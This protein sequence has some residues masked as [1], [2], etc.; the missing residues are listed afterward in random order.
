[1]KILIRLSLSLIVALSMLA[2]TP[3][4]CKVP[5]QSPLQACLEIRR[6]LIFL[7]VNDPTLQQFQY[8]AANWNSPTRQAHLLRKYRQ[9]NC[10]EVL[11]ECPPA[12]V[13]T[14]GLRAP[15]P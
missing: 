10:D 7:G 13:Y 1:M 9:F 2:C 11:R 3:R 14:S 15:C 8:T 12:A 6:Q 4:P 5:P